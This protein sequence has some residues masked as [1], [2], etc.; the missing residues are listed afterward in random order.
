MFANIGKYPP[1]SALLTLSF[2]E[3]PFTFYITVIVCSYGNPFSS[4]F[5]S[6]PS[7]DQ[8][9][10]ELCPDARSP[11]FPRRIS[12]IPQPVTL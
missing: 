9:R 5:P 12:L 2:D 4:R 6:R 8:F 11:T 7:T 3:H 10:A 1:N